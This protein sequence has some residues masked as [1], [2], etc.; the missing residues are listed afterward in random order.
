MSIGERRHRVTFQRAVITKDDFGESDKS[1]TD[2]CTSWALVQP[3]KG[4]ERF[5]ANFAQADID[6]R[7][8]TRN[9]S[10]LKSLGP[11]D[12]IT[13]NGHTYDIR[14][15]I[16]RDHRASDLEILVQEHL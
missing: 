11:K 6:S 8:V 14:A 10:E 3:L 5:S 4:S 16:F 9:R 13:W 12:R 2:I 7:I 15:V 1:W